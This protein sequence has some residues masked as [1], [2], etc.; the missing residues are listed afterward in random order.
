VKCDGHLQY[1]VSKRIVSFSERAVT[2][3]DFFEKRNRDRYCTE[4][5]IVPYSRSPC[6]HQ[7]HGKG[8][9]RCPEPMKNAMMMSTV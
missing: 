5:R 9:G 4:R 3:T 6:P 8:K 2:R 1:C 7:R